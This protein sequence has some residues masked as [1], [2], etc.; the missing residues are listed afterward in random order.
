MPS[1]V[2]FLVLVAMVLSPLLRHIV[3]LAVARRPPIRLFTAA[4][5]G[6][7]LV[8]HYSAT[9]PLH[10]LALGVTVLAGLPAVWIDHYQFRLPDLLTLGPYPL[11]AAV[12][13]ATADADRMVR[14][15]IAAGIVMTAYALGVLAGQLGMGDVKLAGMLSFSLAWNDGTTPLIAVVATLV[16]SAPWA[17]AALVRRRR[18]L[19]YG[20]A[21]VTG[22]ALALLVS[23]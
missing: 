9:D 7:V 11:L 10:Y 22:S 1:A 4:T 17:V 19:P 13:I 5:V 15:P 18:R 12:V 14:I 16:V 21:M 2:P 23:A 3:T 6:A 20:P 8:V